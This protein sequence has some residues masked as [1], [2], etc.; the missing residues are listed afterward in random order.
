MSHAYH[1]LQFHLVFSTKNRLRTITPEFKPK[2]YAYMVGIVRG[3]DGMVTAIGGIEDHVHVLFHTPPKHALSEVIGKIKANSSKWVH[4]TF[5]N[6]ARFGW[7]AGYG[8][9][10]VSESNLAVVKKYIENQEEHHRRLTFQ[11]EFVALLE[12]HGITYDPKYLWD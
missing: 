12:K 11:E 4:E 2:L 7:Q 9:F 6:S 10:S 5:S 3:L 1:R 8:L